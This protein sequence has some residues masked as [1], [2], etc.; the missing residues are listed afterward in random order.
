[1]PKHGADRNHPAH[2]VSHNEEGQVGVLFLYCHA[3]MHYV[4]NIVINILYVDTLSLT[5]SMTNM[6]MTK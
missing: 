4:V 2:G 3:V 6:I 5:V 1:M